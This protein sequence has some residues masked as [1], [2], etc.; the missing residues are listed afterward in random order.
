M[1]LESVK[2]SGFRCF[3]KEEITITIDALTTLIGNNSSGKT[4]A[5]IGLLR[6]FSN[7]PG[8]RIIQ[9]N[10][11]HLAKGTD[12]ESYFKLDLSVE[13]V[14]SFPELLDSNASS[15]AIPIYFK[16]FVVP[17][18]A[19]PPI[20]RIRL[21]SSWERSTSL[22]GSI[23][24]DI[25]YI[26]CS[27]QEKLTE[28]VKII[29]KRHDL[30]KIRMMYIPAQRNPEKQLRNISGSMLYHLLN[31]INWSEDT[32]LS[33]S[34]LTAE[35][36]GVIEMEQG[37][38]AIS[39][40][41][42]TQ[43]KMYD[44]D[45]RYENA[46]LQFNSPDLDSL[47][48]KCEIIFSSEA[49]ARS[50]SIGE[51]GDGLGSL[52]YFSLVDSLL[53]IERLIRKDESEWSSL[54]LPILTIL[55]IEEPENHIAPHLLG[56][57]IMKFKNIIAGKGAQSIITTHSPAIVKRLNPENIRY[58]RMDNSFSTKVKSLTLPTSDNESYKYVKEAVSSYPEIYFAKL[59]ILGEGDSE[60]LI[61]SKILD[62]K[63]NGADSTG[64]S[65]VPLGGR[66]VH[67]FWKLLSDLEIPFITLLDLD[68]ERY[69]GGWSRIKYI[70]DQ[71]LCI[72]I[73]KETL[74]RLE[75][76]EILSDE[77]YFNILN[78]KLSGDLLEKWLNHLEKFGVFFSQP[79]DLDFSMLTHFTENYKKTLS[80]KEGPFI[81]GEVKILELEN[82]P[83]PIQAYNERVANDVKNALKGNGSDGSSYTL[84]ERKLMVW[85][86]Y[87]FLNRGKPTTHFS[88]LANLDDSELLENIPEELKRLVDQI[89][90]TLGRINEYRIEGRPGDSK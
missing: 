30:D 48:K 10:D 85:Y 58:F 74:L 11:F 40:E 9:K 46:T 22:E 64:I 54:P 79:L 70:T 27:E 21:E 84:E 90:R 45:I 16:H 47:I 51:M 8:E 50:S 34:R 88:M 56:K 26:R 59:V 55:A 38:S 35:L 31:G 53:N 49:E 78:W 62:A 80:V 28:D 76:E 77:E 57:L 1:K 33:L 2:Y 61:I 15:S 75:G 69:L 82:S 87:F 25:Y 60:E 42:N 39:N 17:K 7:I 29:A 72:G 24:T 20:L 23:Q 67:H 32:K 86:N 19:E 71:L 89:E 63:N 44:Y 14:F 66:F 36:N 4:S 12:P 43:W 81:K 73:Q 52:F 83:V 37:I 18:P 3:G 68:K 6:I 13:A 5:L 65:V 41:I